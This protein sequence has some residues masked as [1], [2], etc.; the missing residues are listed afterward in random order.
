MR[1]RPRP[2]T[3]DEREA[4]LPRWVRDELAQLRRDLAEALKA[5]DEVNSGEALAW[6]DVYGAHPRPVLRDYEGGIRFTSDPGLRAPYIDVV[7]ARE[8]DGVVE[9]R[10]SEPLVIESRASNVIRVRTGDYR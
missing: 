6:T 10:A 2:S 5:A 4:R 8:E 7:P 9:I 1:A 3:P